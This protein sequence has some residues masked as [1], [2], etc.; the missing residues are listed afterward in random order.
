M[1]LPSE[2]HKKLQKRWIE[3]CVYTRSAGKLDISPAELP[4]IIAPKLV[5]NRLCNT[6][7]E[8]NSVHLKSQE[9]PSGIVSI[10]ED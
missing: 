6:E 8:K 3:K 10:I 9:Q 4:P 7:M 2:F 5:G 1:S